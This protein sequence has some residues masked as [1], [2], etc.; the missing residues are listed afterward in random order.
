MFAKVLIANRGEIACRIIRTARKLD[1]RTVAVYSDA[2]RKALHVRLADETCRIG[3]AE[4][5]ASYLDIESILAAAKETGADAVHPGYGF[6]AENAAF[7]EAVTRAGLVFVGPGPQA[8]RELG[9]KSRA[10]EIMAKAGIP[11]VPGYHGMAQDDATFASEAKRIGFPVLVKAAAGGG[12]RGMRVVAAPGELAQALASVRREAEAAFAD[13]TLLLEKYLSRPRHVEVQIFADAFGNIVHLFERDCSLQRR[14]QKIVEEAPAPGL[15][16]ELRRRMGE[17]AVAGCRAAGYRNAGTVE[18][19]LDADN[20][21]Y[22]ME[23]NTRL[24]VEHPVTEMVTGQNLV[25]WQFRIAAGERLPLGQSDLAIKGHAIEAR[26]YAEDSAHDDR[27]QAGRVVRLMMPAEGTHV[28][29]E[30]GVSEGDEIGVHYDPM[31]AK[32]VVWGEDRLRAVHRLQETL[33]SLRIGGVVT[34]RDLLAAVARHPAFVA[35]EVDTGFIPR[36]RA[37]L[38]PAPSR[39]PDPVLALACLAVLFDQVDRRGLA[40]MR[41]ADRHSPWHRTDGWRLNGIGSQTIRLRDDLGELSVTARFL[42]DGYILD[43]PGGPVRVAG[44]RAPTGEIFADIGGNQVAAFVLHDGFD[45]AVFG[46]GPTWRFRLADPFLAAATED[47][48]AGALVAPMPGKIATVN[49]GAGDTVRRGQVLV[50]LEAMK[51]EHALAASADGRIE[52]IHVRQG[53]QVAE[54][55]LLV[56]F[57]SEGEEPPEG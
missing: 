27:P 30:S 42:S 5:K 23:M 20:S 34:N 37:A 29:V 38:V 28:R 11:T 50:V 9:S 36:H 15:S 39:A 2:D 26:L 44:G 13:P 54:G 25:E 24:Q 6:L 55:D 51:M 19:L 10:K 41:S 53:A 45:I 4:A 52:A 32:I 22:F 35:G 7:A 49:A 14:H 21:F 17:A 40:R 3:P 8:I 48:P 47:A 57:V 16:P 12:G 33:D 56:S 43:L 46:P 18:F 31:I 1:I